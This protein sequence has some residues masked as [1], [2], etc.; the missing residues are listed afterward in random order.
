MNNINLLIVN[1]LDKTL[2]N[3]LKRNGY[4]ITY[5]PRGRND[6]IQ[7][8]DLD[9]YDLIYYAKFVPPYIENFPILFKTRKPLIHATHAPFFIQYFYRPINY[10]YETIMLSQLL[11][12]KTRRNIWI[13]SLNSYE[14]ATLLRLGYST[15]Y[16][17]LGVDTVEFSPKE[18]FYNFTLMFAGARYQKGADLLK[19]IISGVIRKR[20]NTRFI[21]VGNDFLNK[22]LRILR[23]KYPENVEIYDYLPRKIFIDKLCK[24]HI[25]LFPSRYEGCPKILLE[26]LSCRDL[27]VGFKLKGLHSLRLAYQHGA[28]ILSEYPGLEPIIKGVIAYHDLYYNNRERYEK[29]A[30]TARSIAELFDWRKLFKIYDR[31]FKEVKEYSNND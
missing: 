27:I 11:L 20:Q 7:A 13:H 28:A 5:I 22:N 6:F 16:I 19:Y 24:S 1:W 9:K 21:L 29:I 15:Y 31:M 25:L 3:L 8:V 2:Y 4:K 23:D 12:F 26:A 30:D 10:F 17:P 14:Y 18:K